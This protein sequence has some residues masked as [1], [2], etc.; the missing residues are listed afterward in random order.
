MNDSMPNFD[1]NGWFFLGFVDGGEFKELQPLIAKY[2]CKLKTNEPEEKY[3]NLHGAFV[4][5]PF[6]IDS[7]RKRLWG[8]RWATYKNWVND[9]PELKDFDPRKVKKNET[10][11]RKK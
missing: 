2:K 10:K 5:C 4:D 7:I 9:N 6:R 1:K 3:G 11:K 8:H